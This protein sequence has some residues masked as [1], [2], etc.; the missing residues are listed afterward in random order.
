MTE[1]SILFHPVLLKS[2]RPEL[3]QGMT[4]THGMATLLFVTREEAEHAG[5]IAWSQDFNKHGGVWT[6]T[7]ELPVAYEMRLHP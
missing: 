2:G 4:P 5:A 1:S 7:T 3:L 6:A